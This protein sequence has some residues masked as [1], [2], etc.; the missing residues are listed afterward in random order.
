MAPPSP[1]VAE[2]EVFE[3]IP[4][5]RAILED[6]DYA[7]EPTASRI[8]KPQTNED[9]LLARTLKTSDTIRGWVSLYRR[10]Q[11]SSP[12]KDEVRTIVSLAPGLDGYP[13]VCHG[14]IVATLLDEVLSLLVAV[15]RRSQ[16]LLPDNVTADLHL[17]YVKPVPTP[18]VLLVRGKV[19]EIKGRKHYAD[20]EIVDGEGR[21]L[22]KADGLFISVQK[23]KL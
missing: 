10:P 2:L 13:G 20:G 3:K 5:C 1:R 8:Y 18:A 15:C 4:W 23:E 12:L 9:A 7:A 11:P 17:T 21:V 22:A 19:R 6:G 14:G 16:G